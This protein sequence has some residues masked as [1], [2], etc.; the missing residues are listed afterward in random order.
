MQKGV[1]SSHA[2]PAWRGGKRKTWPLLE[3]KKKGIHAEHE[4]GGSWSWAQW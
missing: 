3:K 2:P 4:M 1:G